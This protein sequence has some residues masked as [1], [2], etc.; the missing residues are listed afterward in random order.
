VAE[1][2]VE[3]EVAAVEAANR[4]YDKVY[5]EAKNAYD[6]VVASAEKDLNEKLAVAR[7]KRD[8]AIEKAYKAF[9]DSVEA[10]PD[11]GTVREVEAND[12]AEG[13]ERGH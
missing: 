8:H 9:Y 3:A 1:Y 6:S 2:S 13:R 7:E 5:K 11:S 12:T 10:G 4:H